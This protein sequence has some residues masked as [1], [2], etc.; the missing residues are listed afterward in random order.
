MAHWSSPHPLIL[1]STD[2]RHSQ[3]ATAHSTTTPQ[4]ANVRSKGMHSRQP[5]A[6]GGVSLWVF[7]SACAPLIPRPGSIDYQPGVGNFSGSRENTLGLSASRLPKLP[8]LCGLAW[9]SQP[10]VPLGTLYPKE[11]A[12]THAHSCY[13][14]VV[15]SE[16]AR[17]A[18][19]ASTR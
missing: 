7:W 4:L 15:S 18:K 12:C 11:I 9:L 16:G 8:R 1:A 2:L 19:A 6:R 3:T 10:T 14:I 5:V 17:A 13:L